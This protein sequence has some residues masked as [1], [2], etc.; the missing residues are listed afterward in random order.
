MMREKMM[1]KE[2]MKPQQKMMNLMS[3]WQK[4]RRKLNPG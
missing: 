1:K 2:N 3:H 4:W